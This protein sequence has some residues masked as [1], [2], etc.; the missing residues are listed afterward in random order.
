MKKIVL[1][2]FWSLSLPAWA[3][4]I[5][6][7]GVGNAYYGIMPQSYR[8]FVGVR[9]RY[10]TYDSHLNSQLLRTKE[11]FQTTELWGRFYPTQRIQMLAFVPYNFNYQ[12]DAAT[13]SR[14]NGLGDITVL[15]N[16]N[17]FNTNMDTTDRAVNHTL[18]LGGG[19]KLATGRSNF[20]ND[21]SLGANANFQLGTGSTDFLLN[22]IYTL[23]YRSWGWN[24]DVSYRMTTTNA[25]HYRF[26][27]RLSGSTSV[28]YVTS[29]GKKLTLMPN[30]GITAEY[31]SRDLKDGVRN[32]QTGGYATLATAGVEAYFG[33]F[34]AGANV[35]QPLVQN[36]SGGDSRAK[37]RLQLHVTVLL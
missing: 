31:S 4:D 21:G 29:T 12:S 28:F 34:V 27:N 14:L 20:V 24:S 30:A 13:S 8:N 1:L 6:G 35:Q 11:T 16:Y 9:Y 26:G 23:R 22:A 3:C 15:A 2:L 37:Q 5:C 10:R 18:L 17:V 7:C 25:Q 32:S 19:I 36:L 33:R